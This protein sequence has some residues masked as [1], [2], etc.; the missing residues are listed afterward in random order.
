MD[1]TLQGAEK[2]KPQRWT[3]EGGWAPGTTEGS[4]ETQNPFPSLVFS[5]F[6]WVL[7]HL[8]SCE[9]SCGFTSALWSGSEVPMS[10]CCDSGFEMSSGFQCPVPLTSSSG[11]GAR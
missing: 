8:E 5:T 7:L 10:Q 9:L 3:R 2:G 6:V 11:V 4:T 1:L